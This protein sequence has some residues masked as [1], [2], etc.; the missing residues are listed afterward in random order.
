MNL[1]FR[2]FLTVILAFFRPRLGPL[3]ESVV[4]FRVWPNDLDLNAH[5]NNGRYLT[6]M[7]LGRMDLIVRL[8]LFGP[9]LKNKWRPA[10]ASQTILFRRSLK[11]FQK[12]EL[13]TRI[14]GWDTK[15]IYLEQ[16]FMIGVKPAARALVKALILEPQGAVPTSVLFA[17]LS[18]PGSGDAVAV[19][20]P[21]PEDVSAWVKAD[22]L[23]KLATP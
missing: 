22:E 5:M 4:K 23:L 18:L 3:E 11:P 17:E 14:L 9:S 1:Y 8:G 13:R 15:W 21:M 12:Y 2:F 16:L 10:V 20:P 7:D 19:S 6:L